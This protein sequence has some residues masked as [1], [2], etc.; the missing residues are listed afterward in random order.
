MQGTGVIGRNSELRIQNSGVRS[1]RSYRICAGFRP[2]FSDAAHPTAE[3]SVAL[4]FD[5]NPT[6]LHQQG[7]LLL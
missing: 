5:V 7:L 4:P 3:Y 2:M 6:Q 1:C